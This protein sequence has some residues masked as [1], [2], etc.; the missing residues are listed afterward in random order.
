MSEKT[1]LSLRVVYN[2]RTALEAR[3]YD[4]PSIQRSP[5]YSRP[6]WYCPREI[7]TRIENA[8]VLVGSDAHI[9]DEKPLPI[10]LAF[11]AVAAE[12]KP[13]AIVLNGDII[14]GAR[15]SRHQKLP[16]STPTMK[17]ELAAVGANLALIPAAPER[18]WTMGNHDA[19]VDLYLAQRAPELEDYAGSLTDRFGDWTFSWSLVVN[20]NTEIR[21]RF[22]GGIH[23]AY[24]NVLQAGINIVTG[25]THGLEM[26]SITNRRGVFFG[27]ETGMLGDPFGPQ[28]QY[29]EGMPYRAC[30]GFAL[31]TFDE[32]GALQPPELCRWQNGAAYFR[33]KKVSL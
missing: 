2:R 30:P 28:F 19:R 29:G 23:T 9:W 8:C 14:D 3:G 26:R 32:R 20:E 12:V 27:I 10:W 17:D 11:C 22:R 33:N 31:L 6:R 1:G 5:G 24:N 4:L 16:G 25:D 15:I 7:N 18:Y 13:Q 21:H